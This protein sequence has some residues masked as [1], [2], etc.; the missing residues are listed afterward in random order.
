MGEALGRINN[1]IIE[2]LYEAIAR[3][4]K[5]IE[6]STTGA[7]QI[8]RTVSGSGICRGA[9]KRNDHAACNKGM[10]VMIQTYLTVE[11]VAQILERGAEQVR[12]MACIG[13][14]TIVFVP[15]N[16]EMVPSHLV[17]AFT[18]VHEE[19]W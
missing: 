8:A 13:V 6:L 17:P 2:C 16:G 15:G 9:R 4:E 19:E 18:T 1:G 11:E 7:D 14:L 12:E 5:A 10:R 3:I